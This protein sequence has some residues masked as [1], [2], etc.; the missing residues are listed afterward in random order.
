[1]KVVVYDQ[2]RLKEYDKAM[3]LAAKELNRMWKEPPLS[4]AER[5]ER[6]A[7]QQRARRAAKVISEIVL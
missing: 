5:R 4:R 1:M 3:K 7:E 6:R 2:K